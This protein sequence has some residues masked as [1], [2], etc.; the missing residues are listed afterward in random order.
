MPRKSTKQVKGN[1]LD[2]LNQTHGKVENPVTLEQVWGDDGLNKYGTLDTEKYLEYVNSLNKSD[3]QKHA[4]KIGLVPIDDRTN[5]IAR[6]KKEFVKHT[7]KYSARTLAPK[8]D[9]SKK[10]KDILAEGR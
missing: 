10:A 6:L 5:L 2:N 9:I 1:K 7:A 8:K 3:L 4:V